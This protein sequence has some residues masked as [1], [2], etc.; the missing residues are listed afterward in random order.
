MKL[1]LFFLFLTLNSNQLFAQKDSFDFAYDTF[2]LAKQSGIFGKLGKRIT[3]DKPN[4]ELIKTGTIKVNLPFNKYRGYVIKHIHIISLELNQNLNDT[5]EHK[6]NLLVNVGNWLHKKTTKQ[7]IRNNLFFKVGD[8]VQPYLLADNERHL[9]EQAYLQDAKIVVAPLAFENA[10][11]VFVYTK[12]VFSIGAS[13][14]VGS[15]NNFNAELKDEN[16]LGNTTRIALKFLYD[17][18]RRP[19]TGLGGEIL[20]RN[21]AGTFTDL[22][23]GFRSFN[24]AFNSGKPEELYTYLKLE[25]PLVSPYMPFTG[26]I[27][28]AWHKTSNA[29]IRDSIYKSQVNYEFVDYDVWGGFNLGC[30]KLLQNNTPKRIRQFIALR[31]LHHQFQQIPSIYQNN[32]NYIYADI[33]GVLGAINIFKQNFYKTK[34][35]FGFGRQEDV[36]EGF[37]LSLMGGWTNKQ[38][39]SRAYGGID[40]SRKY[41]GSKGNYYNYTFR[42][43]GFNY[44][45]NFEDINILFNLE[46]FSRL[47][48]FGRRWQLRSFT[49]FGIT[50]Q[51]NPKLDQPLLLNSIYGL[52]EISNGT[53]SAQTRIT[54]KRE[55]AIYSKWNILGC[56][57]APFI[58]SNGCF[59]IPTN[60]NLRKGEFYSSLGGGLRA[61]NEALIFGTVEC[62]FNYF[63]RINNGMQ[64][65]RFDFKTDLQF[66]YNSQY[67]RKPDFVS[68]N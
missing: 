25:K 8:E 54:L 36:P 28:L 49:N 9:R 66:K 63:P 30:K 52:P 67:I 33:T 53:I 62:R 20:Q 39:L 55:I 48:T 1:I 43:G 37:S 44:N 24:T 22:T 16:F 3:A 7:N 6:K 5:N 61:R 42:M 14:N 38:N 56:R 27:D 35:I 2:F 32:Y 29:Y 21:I 57:F 10:V 41:F 15:A 13:L 50:Q 68:P 12:D 31:L 40:F 46:Y 17:E 64:S 51:I 59:L 34:Y 45:N 19:N 47:K 4:P 65:Y 58:F 11:D 26:E 60:E 18:D 23:L